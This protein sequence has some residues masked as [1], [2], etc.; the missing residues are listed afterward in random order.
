MTDR[1]PDPAIR[2]DE[3]LRVVKNTDLDRYELWRGEHFIGFEGF[4]DHE[5]GT[6]ELQHTIIGEQFGFVGSL[7]VLGSYLV[8]FAAGV[9]IAASTREP[10]GRLLA[11]GIVS[12]LAGQVFINL[13]VA[14]RLFP[15]TGITLPFVSYGGS[16]VL[17]S[18][19]M[20]GL[21]LAVSHRSRSA[22]EAPGS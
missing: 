9:E 13:M 14:L 12:V 17:T 1:H 11:V 4:Q 22:D 15:V 16:S 7:V 5:D 6:V 8:L 21:L 10:F 18:F 2:D 19:I 3:Q 20:V